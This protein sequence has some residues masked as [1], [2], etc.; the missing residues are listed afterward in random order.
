MSPR[1]AARLAWS[2]WGLFVVLGGTGIYLDTLNHGVQLED[3]VSA[4]VF[5]MLGT[6]GALLAARRPANA[7]AW[8]FLAIAV[9]PGIGYF[10][11]QYAIYSLVTRPGSLPWGRVLH[12]LSHFVWSTILLLIFLVLLFPDG[13]LPSTRWRPVAR[14]TA[15]LIAVA[16]LSLAIH[17]GAVEG[18]ERFGNPFGIEAAKPILD[19]VL[20]VV[21]PIVGAMGVVA[22]ASLA[23]R[24]RR[25]GAVERQQLK[26]FMYA[27][28]VAVVALA[29]GDFLPDAVGL[30]LFA[31][32]AG[33]LPVA[34][35]IAILRYRL[36]DIDRIVNRTL[37]YGLL[38]LLLAGVYVGAVVGL[39]TLVGNSTILVAASTL[40]V[41]A[42]FRP[43]RRRVQA[44]IDRRFYRRRYDAARTLEAFTARLREEV[45]LDSLTEDLVG[46]VR[47]TMQPARASL[48]LR[49]PEGHR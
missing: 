20:A 35:T 1:S 14:L 21:F 42:L 39:G 5:I 37:V 3:V 49:T 36:W 8:L 41:A 28:V 15:F 16:T 4:G 44:I 2:L 17:P 45:D 19:V 22:L 25:G 43:A 33:A 30:G 38:T 40:L 9:G 32:G 10:A 31:V 47:D 34:T 26:W 23:V 11:E 6:F 48:W 46:V 27:A 12:A 13:R 18:L 7:V 29:G 24:F